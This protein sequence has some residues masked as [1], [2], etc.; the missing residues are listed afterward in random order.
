MAD[1]KT[2]AMSAICVL[3]GL[4]VLA[5]FAT[6]G[7]P[8]QARKEN[9]DMTR[10]EDLQ[11]ISLHIACRADEAGTLPDAPAE[12]PGCPAP[13]R[14][15]D[16]YTDAPYLYAP[17][18]PR[19]WR[20]CAGFERPQALKARLMNTRFDA[21]AGCLLDSFGDPHPDAETDPPP[22]PDPAP[23]SPLDAPARTR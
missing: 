8:I 23:A 17:T 14:M 9:R 3:A 1:R 18:G 13:P 16:P 5:G 12:T 11:Q 15:A 6:S 22:A 21:E 10:W 7:G 20:I 4:A 19:H 2:V